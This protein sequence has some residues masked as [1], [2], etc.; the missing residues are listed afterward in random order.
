[1]SVISLYIAA[2]A[3]RLGEWQVEG[4]VKWDVFT[5][6]VSEVK[7]MLNKTPAREVNQLWKL[8]SKSN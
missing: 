2:S 4:M 8:P 6:G 1:M 3:R 5:Q 7:E